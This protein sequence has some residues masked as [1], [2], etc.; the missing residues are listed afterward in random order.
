MSAQ[1]VYIV[2]Y[3]KIIPDLNKDVIVGGVYSTREKAQKA[4][5]K[6]KDMTKYEQITPY[7]WLN[8]DSKEIITIWTQTV[9]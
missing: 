4:V 5:E 7:D 2:L 8:R 6:N 1:I 3:D 9:K